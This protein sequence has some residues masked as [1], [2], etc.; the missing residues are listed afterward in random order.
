MKNSHATPMRIPK[1]FSVFVL[2]DKSVQ[3]TLDNYDGNFLSFLIIVVAIPLF[4]ATVLLAFY[5]NVVFILTGILLL[6]VI[7]WCVY[8]YKDRSQFIFTKDTFIVLEGMYKRETCHVKY[9]DIV[10]TERVTIPGSTYA[11]SKT[12][13]TTIN[14][15][16][17]ELY[18]HTKVERI[19]VT[20]DVGQNGQAYLNTLIQEKIGIP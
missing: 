6:V 2:P 12:G 7:Y 10:R 20:K 19:L 16:N 1:D 18:I 15:P 17:Y 4:I 13:N 11:S 5:L 9:K 8:H 3:V 14:H